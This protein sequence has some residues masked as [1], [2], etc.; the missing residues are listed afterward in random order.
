MTKLDA[1]RKLIR[2]ELRQV[3]KEELRPILLEMKKQPLNTAPTTRTYTD[4]LKESIKTK[5]PAVSRKPTH[6][7]ST[8]DPIMDLLNE[9]AYGMDT[10]E[11]R[12]LVNADAG[13]AQGFPQMY[14]Q[15][16][17]MPMAE[18]QVVE[19]VQEMIASTGPVTDIH[20]VNI[21]AV[22][23]FSAMMQTLKSKGAI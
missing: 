21:D 18:P 10:S 8:G 19:S 7:V 15:S 2:E 12:S 22:P 23:D 6:Q 9:T 14:Q 5:T 4:T 13:M 20:Q 3:L 11:Y 17:G 1:F 16:A